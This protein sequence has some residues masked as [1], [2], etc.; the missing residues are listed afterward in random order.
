MLKPRALTPHLLRELATGFQAS[1]VL[2]T[3]I[4]LRVFSL[5]GEKPSS[6]PDVAALAG[7]DARATDRLLNALC[8]MGLLLKHSGLFSNTNDGSRYL[9][10]SSPD[11]VANLGHTAGMWQ[12]W[13][14]LT[15]SVRTGRA[16]L[17]EPVNDRGEGWLEPFIAAMHYRARAQA[18]SV[19]KLLPLDGVKRA[20]DVGGGSG[21]FA[22][23]M[24]KQQPGLN[25]VV[26][27][28]PNVVPLT[29][30]YV[31]DAGLDDR[32]STVPGDY[33]VDVLP[34]D[35][36]LVLLSAV[37]HS[38]TAE[39][40]A[41]LVKKCAGTLNPGGRVAILDWVMSSDRTLPDAGTFFA[42]NMLVAADGGDTFTEEEMTSWLLD[43]GLSNV[44]RIATPFGTD[45][46]VGVRP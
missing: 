42:L 32:V 15:E 16:A 7:T 43:A 14:T 27:D 17:R 33:L 25:A 13:A 1:R 4:E 29:Q 2:L 40:N 19:A 31:A 45:L 36:D 44:R 11:F 18:G 30:R 12:T 3:A 38:N 20:L 5:I 41:A 21:A 35:F 9:V 37:V 10:D 46:M 24:V 6:A 23:A 26:F 39:D 22:M 8:A 28:L 34:Q